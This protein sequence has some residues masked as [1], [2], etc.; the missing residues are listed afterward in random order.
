MQPVLKHRKCGRQ[1]AEAYT[2]GRHVLRQVAAVHLQQQH[3]SKKGH[4][5]QQKMYGCCPLKA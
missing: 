2:E 1:Q 5:Q 4:N 3:P